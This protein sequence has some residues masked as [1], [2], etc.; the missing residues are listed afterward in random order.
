MHV[1][2][3]NFHCR[4]ATMFFVWHTVCQQYT[5]VYTMHCKA[6]M[7]CIN[8]GRSELQSIKKTEGQRQG[9]LNWNSKFSRNLLACAFGQTAGYLDFYTE[10]PLT[11]SVMI[12]ALQSNKPICH[13]ERKTLI[14]CETLWPLNSTNCLAEHRT[15]NIGLWKPLI[16]PGS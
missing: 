16:M 3:F 8:L 13:L 9:L 10:S 11:R 12:S 15:L 5:I 1:R 2:I 6:Y 14:Q 7:L 4:I